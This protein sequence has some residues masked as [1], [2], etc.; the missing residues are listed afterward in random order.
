MVDREAPELA[1][2]AGIP[3][4]SEIPRHLRPR[5]A[6]GLRSIV[7]ELPILVGATVEGS[8]VRIRVAGKEAS[9]IV[10]RLTGIRK[11]FKGVRLPAKTREEFLKNER[12]IRKVHGN[13]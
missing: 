9:R 12:F 3:D 10:L 8:D 11:G 13:G 1:T 5:N 4:R 6:S 2:R 7:P